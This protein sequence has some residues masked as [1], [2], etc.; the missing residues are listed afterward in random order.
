M[1][2]IKVIKCLVNNQPAVSALRQLREIS[3][4]W[5]AIIA[6][7]QSVI[8]IGHVDVM[9]MLPVPTADAPPQMRVGD[10]HTEGISSIMI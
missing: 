2:V 8:T 3:A 1:K 5:N 9:V 6:F 7:I 4:S 10:S